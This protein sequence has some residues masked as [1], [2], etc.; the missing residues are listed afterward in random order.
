MMM[1]MMMM[2]EQQ[3][4]RQCFGTVTICKICFCLQAY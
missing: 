2:M 1:M 3:E 4:L